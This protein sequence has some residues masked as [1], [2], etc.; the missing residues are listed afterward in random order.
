M[1][2]QDFISDSHLYPAGGTYCTFCDY[3]AITNGVPFEIQN[4]L[5]HN[6]NFN[7]EK[8]TIL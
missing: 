1:D 8:K 5:S 7:I 6:A 2:L 3:I 4:R